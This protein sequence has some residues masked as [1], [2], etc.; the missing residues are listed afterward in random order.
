MK[1]K[2]ILL[3]GGGGFLGCALARRL[4]NQKKNVHVITPG[5]HPAVTSNA[6]I[7]QTGM[8]DEKILKTILL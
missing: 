3:L 7:H 5:K 2:G 6:I 8:D 1:K 4:S